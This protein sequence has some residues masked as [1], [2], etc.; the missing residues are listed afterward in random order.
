MSGHP[1]AHK[2]HRGPRATGATVP[3]GPWSCP[4]GAASALF[5]LPAN[6]KRIWQP[7]RA[8]CG[9]TS[10]ASG[11]HGWY[12][13]SARWQW[14]LS[15]FQASGCCI[16]CGFLRTANLAC[17]GAN[18]RAISQ[19]Q[20]GGIRGASPSRRGP[21]AALG[22]HR[23]QSGWCKPFYRGSIGDSGDLR[24]IWIHPAGY[25][26]QWREHRGQCWRRTGRRVAQRD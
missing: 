21:E 15:Q 1:R 17:T 19:E 20:R 18:V 23:C 16:S 9:S 5:N 8:S 13:R 2:G 24:C 11:L 14:S 12:G 7:Q 22:K 26:T 3:T 25:C 6:A 4:A 10:I